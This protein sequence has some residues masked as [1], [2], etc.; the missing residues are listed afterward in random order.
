VVRSQIRACIPVKDD[1]EKTGCQVEAGSEYK[2]I[3]GCGTFTL[4]EV[5]V[6]RS[7]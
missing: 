1:V 6:A 2:N 7:G 4:G 3:E 5:V